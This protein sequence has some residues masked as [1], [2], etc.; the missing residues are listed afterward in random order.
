M[1]Y[2]DIKITDPSSGQVVAPPGLASLLA[3]SSYTSFLAGQTLP[4]ALKVELDLPIIGAATPQGFGLVRVWGISLAE[5][6]QATNLGAKAAGQP[7][8]NITVRGGMQKGLPL[9]NPAQSGVLFQGSIV[10]AFGNWIGTDMTLDIVVMPGASTGSQPGGAGTLGK[11]KNIVLN[12]K[13]GTPLSNALK[14]ALQT[15]FPGYTGKMNINSGIVR[16]GDQI[17][18]Y[19]TLEQLAQF[20]RQI[21]ID[22]IKTSGYPGVTIAPPATDNTINVFDGSSSSSGSGQKQINFWDLI[23]QPTWIESPNIQFKTVMRADIKLGDEIKLPPTLV[24]NTA[25]AQSSLTNQNVAFQGGFTIVNGRHV[26]DSRQPTGDA[27]VTVFEG[28]PKQVQGT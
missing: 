17:G 23:G 3:G 24:Q 27:W 28:A 22:S 12:W 13:A 8:K 11:P 4:G 16:P 20:V 6:G 10:Q 26:G 15:A 19:P 14:S 1:R 9:A 5:I 18:Y 2:Y 25:Q 7:G 21:S